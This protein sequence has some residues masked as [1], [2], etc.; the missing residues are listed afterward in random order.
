MRD[1]KLEDHGDKNC[2]LNL[3]LAT[4]GLSS[5]GA[6]SVIHPHARQ[7]LQQADKQLLRDRAQV[8]AHQYVQILDKGFSSTPKYRE[9]PPCIFHTL[10]EWLPSKRLPSILS[11][12]ED[13]EGAADIGP[14]H[15]LI[16]LYVVAEPF[17]EL[18]L[19]NSLLKQLVEYFEPGRTPLHST[20]M[21]A[22]KYYA[23][24][25]PI[26]DLLVDAYCRPC[27]WHN[28]RTDCILR[29]DLP[30]AFI[31]R[32]IEV[33]HRFESQEVRQLNLSKYLANQERAYEAIFQA[34]LKLMNARLR[35]L[36]VGWPHKQQTASEP[37]RPQ[38]RASP[39]PPSRSE[40]EGQDHTVA[41]S[42]SFL[43][44]RWDVISVK[45]VCRQREQ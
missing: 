33:W 40:K 36:G 29:E 8:L 20:I 4:K 38:K 13:Y 24:D 22:F 1:P 15:R 9:I 5:Q 16:L 32:C 44:T 11:W 18:Q 17:R 42:Q 27:I 2:F 31:E 19:Q 28:L 37:L 21:F 6:T 10:A 45:R 34:D 23:P 7:I 39:F 14:E 26:A 35:D 25:S 30:V 43:A 41:S 12:P 3:H